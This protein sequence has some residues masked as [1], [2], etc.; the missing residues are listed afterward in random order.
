MS[1]RTRAHPERWLAVYFAATGQW[2]VL[3]NAPYLFGFEELPSVAWKFVEWLYALGAIGYLLFIRI[4]FRPD[5]AWAAALVW[6]GAAFLLVGAAGA[7]V[8]AGFAISLASPWFL[9]EWVGY[10]LASVWM[11]AESARAHVLAKRRVRIGLCPAIVANR[12]L[13]FAAFSLFQALAS[14]I[15]LVWASELGNSGPYASLA[16]RALSGTEIASVALL[17]LAFF[18]PAAYR[19]WIEQ[20]T[21]RH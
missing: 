7:S 15:E 6:I 4:V 18:P 17:W 16:F 5:A 19:K 10:T 11:C 8:G 13:L 12:Y 14:L 9:M 1:L 3:Y 2:F 20:R 21:E